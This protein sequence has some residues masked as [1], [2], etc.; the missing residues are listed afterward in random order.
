MKFDP[1]RS[2]PAGYWHF[3]KQY[4]Q[5][6]EAVRQDRRNLMSPALQLY[7]Q[8]IE[9]SLKSFLLKR[10]ETLERV[11]SLRHKLDELLALSR[12]RRLGLQVKLS[13]N[14]VALIHLLN[15][16][17]VRHRFRYIVTG[18]TRVPQTGHIAVVAERLLAG[19]ERYCANSSWGLAR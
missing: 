12:R 2:T 3:A 6:A 9:L 15:A 4:F 10:G 7:G 13:A 8:A 17:Y 14:D 1:S 11:E 5:A 16:S 19:L 18:V